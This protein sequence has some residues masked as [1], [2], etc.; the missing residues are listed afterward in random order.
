MLEILKQKYNTGSQ[1]LLYYWKENNGLEID[2]LIDNGKKIVLVEIKAS[3]TF[4]NSYFK[5]L[6]HWNKISGN[7]GGIVVYDGKKNIA[8]SGN[9]LITDWQDLQLKL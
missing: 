5:N 8:L 7:K 3:Q 9:Y 6:I 1:A 4:D 2:L